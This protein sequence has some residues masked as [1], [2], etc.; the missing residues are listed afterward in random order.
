MAPEE[1]P[2]AAFV[3]LLVGGIIPKATATTAAPATGTTTAT[4]Q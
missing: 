2:T 4:S 1:R 3:L